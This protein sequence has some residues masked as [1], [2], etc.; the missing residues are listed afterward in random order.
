MS[1]QANT[2]VMQAGEP[3]DH[4]RLSAHPRAKRSIA[5]AKAFGGLL[6]FVIGLW[7]GWRAGLPSWDSGVRGLTGGIAGYML[8]WVGSVQFWRQYA[9][10]EYRALRRRQQERIREYNERMEELRRQRT[11][12]VRAANEALT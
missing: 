4:I 2:T 11:E 5:R 6:G 12:A 1:D 8:L 10:A 7:M 3:D 9:R